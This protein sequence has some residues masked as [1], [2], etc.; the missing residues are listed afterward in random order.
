MK[1]VIRILGL[2]CMT[3]LLA[4][5]TSCKKE[6]TKTTEIEVVIPGM[7]N[8]DGERAYIDSEWQFCWLA[9]D[10]IMVYNLDAP[11]TQTGQ[12]ASVCGVYQNTSGQVPRAKFSGPSLGKK[13]AKDYRYFYPVNMVQP[14]EASAAANMI[15]LGDENRQTFYVKPVQHYNYFDA[16]GHPKSRVDVSS[17]PM[18]IDT[19]NL[20]ASATLQHMFGT[21]DIQLLAAT[22]ADIV[23]NKVIIVDNVYHLWGNC[24]VKLH[25][26]DMDVLTTMIEDE[27]I[28][29]ATSSN[30]SLYDASFASYVIG[31]LGWTSQAGV[32]PGVPEAANDSVM[33][34]MVLDC[35]H[36][37]NG[38]QVGVTLNQ[39]PNTPSEFCFMLRPLALSYGFKIYV[40]IEGRQDLL[41][42]DSWSD[43]KPSKVGSRCMVPG[44]YRVF[45]YDFGIQ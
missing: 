34:T 32:Y 14:D 24:T 16:P 13:L 5:A 10:Q 26:V 6:N 11:D 38:E 35:V 30:L 27:F 3:G 4:I 7:S 41:Y 15:A 2:A 33:R 28:P 42:I 31:D 39:I 19:K 37:E 18:S 1:R 8:V 23:V 45:R 29:G 20:K 12:T 43:V 17:M 44:T 36:T 9:G 25:P 40:E 21:A 22:D